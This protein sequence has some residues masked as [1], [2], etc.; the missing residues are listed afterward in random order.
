MSKVLITSRSFGKV[1]KNSI[2]MLEEGGCEIIKS[3]YPRALKEKELLE[4]IEGIDAVIVGVDEVTAR[5]IEIADRLKVIS[6]HGVGV[7]N[8]DVE[9]ASK[10][11]ILV[12]TTPGTN[13]NAVAD[14]TFALILSLSRSI[15]KADYSLKCGEWG[16]IIGHETG[17]KILGVVGTGRIGRAVINRAG[18]FDM[19]VL[20]YDITP[21]KKLAS[22]LKVEYVS[23]ETLLASSDF[24]T[25]HI[26]LTE[27]TRNMLGQKEISL[28]KPCAYLIN[29][30]RGGILDEDALYSALKEKKIA[31]AAIDV[32]EEEPPPADSRLLKLDNLI[33]TPHIAAYTYEALREMGIMTAKNVLRVLKG[34]PPISAANFPQFHR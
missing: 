10:K 31:G 4:L 32:Y 11:G 25:L 33:T 29:T 6:K 20:A 34:E 17:G 30:A 26:P 12:T 28:M 7:D 24:V 9:A 3:P 15:C 2:K 14:F 19:R 13:A 21:D 22:Q 8:V 16:R 18:G 23:L 1:Y 5:V 27:K